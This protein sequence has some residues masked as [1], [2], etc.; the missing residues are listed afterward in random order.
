MISRQIPNVSR[1]VKVFIYI[2]I[3]I[4]FAVSV[5]IKHSLTWLSIQIIVASLTTF[6]VWS[7]LSSKKIGIN[8]LIEIDPIVLLLLAAIY[9]LLSLLPSP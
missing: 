2:F 6:N 7:L 9:L 5:S 3:G 4:I 1:I 8:L